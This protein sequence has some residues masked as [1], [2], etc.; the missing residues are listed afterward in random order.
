MHGVLE[1]VS[2]VQSA[3]PLLFAEILRDYL[4]FIIV[5]LFEKLPIPGLY[6]LEKLIS[7][8]ILANLKIFITFP[9]YMP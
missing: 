2:K 5:L 7:T 9:Y 6:S 3:Y 1:L 8:I 4:K